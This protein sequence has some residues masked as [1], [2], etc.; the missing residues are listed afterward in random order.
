[1]P[2]NPNIDEFPNT[3]FPK[4]S[5]RGGLGKHLFRFYFPPVLFF[6]LAKVCQI[7]RQNYPSDAAKAQIYPNDI[8]PVSNYPLLFA[9]GNTIAAFS[10]PSVAGSG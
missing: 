2:T 4:L 7:S 9:Q 3:S 6:G 8:N 5:A 1:M 10:Y